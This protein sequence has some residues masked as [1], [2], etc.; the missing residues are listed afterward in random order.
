VISTFIEAGLNHE[1]RELIVDHNTQLDQNYFRPSEEQVLREFLKAEQMLTVDPS[2]RL[3]QQ[4]QTLKIEKSKMER[5]EQRMEEYD[6]VLA[7]FTE[8]KP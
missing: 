3:A 5:L 4:V 8:V 7:Q 6:R 1:I 2:A